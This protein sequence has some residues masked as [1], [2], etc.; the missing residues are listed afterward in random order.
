MGYNIYSRGK[1]NTTEVTN[2]GGA[3]TNKIYFSFTDGA[4]DLGT[5]GDV[6][7]IIF[8]DFSTNFIRTYYVRVGRVFKQFVYNLYNFN[9]LKITNLPW[10]FKTTYNYLLQNKEIDCL[11][12][13]LKK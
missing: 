11:N 12:K 13:Q 1:I 8:L 10:L 5:F 9:T 2:S 6:W 3:F 7:N 4:L